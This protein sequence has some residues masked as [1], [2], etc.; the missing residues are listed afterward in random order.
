VEYF[1]SVFAIIPISVITEILD[2]QL[3]TT[4]K[5]NE[6]IEE[7]KSSY[8]FYLELLHLLKAKKINDDEINLLEKDFINNL[9]YFPLEKY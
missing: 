9:K 8:K 1:K 4:V 3:N 2:N 5:L 6:H 7:Y